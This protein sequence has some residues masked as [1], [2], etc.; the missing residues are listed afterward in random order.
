VKEIQNHDLELE[1]VGTGVNKED[2]ELT[3][4]EIVRLIRLFSRKYDLVM[5]EA[6]DKLTFYSKAES[7]TSMNTCMYLSKWLH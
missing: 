6:T 5:L 1:Y 4:I 2:R 3:E 7:E